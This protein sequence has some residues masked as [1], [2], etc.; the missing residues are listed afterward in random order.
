MVDESKLTKIVIRTLLVLDSS[1][2]R[3]EAEK[4]GKTFSGGDTDGITNIFFITPDLTAAQKS[5]IQTLI[6]KIGSGSVT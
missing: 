2:I 6:D 3:Q 5:T 4:L 1:A